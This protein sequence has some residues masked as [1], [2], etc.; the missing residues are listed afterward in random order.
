[1]A[2]IRDAIFPEDSPAVLDIWREFVAS[3]SVSLAHQNNQLEFDNIPGKYAA[4]D[5]CIL[6]ADRDG[7]ID[8]CVSIKRVDAEICEMKRLYVRPRA[9]GTRLGY[10]LIESVISA[11]RDLGYAEM[12]LDVLAEFVQARQLY[13]AFGFVAAEPIS[14]N[15]IPGTDFLGLRL[16]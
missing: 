6:L 5:G 10:A 8:G 14:F 7:L 9:R 1:M 15:P 16:N 13:A 4:P 2:L 12:R 3:P 11:A